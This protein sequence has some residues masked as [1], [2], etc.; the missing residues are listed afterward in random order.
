[1]KFFRVV[2]VVCAAATLTGCDSA[3]GGSIVYGYI[4]YA[5]AE[6][7]ITGAYRT[8]MTGN[9]DVTFMHFLTNGDIEV[10]FEIA[11]HITPDNGV[12]SQVQYDHA[13]ESGYEFEYE[14]LRYL[15]T[16]EEHTATGFTSKVCPMATIALKSRTYSDY[17]LTA[18][19]MTVDNK[20]VNIAFKGMIGLETGM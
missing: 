15:I 2:S 20:Q 17:V 18:S 8:E 12:Y 16:V 5:G 13:Y 9:R 11:S 10:V 6:Y 19:G 7:P 3:E 14:I 4:E 1:M